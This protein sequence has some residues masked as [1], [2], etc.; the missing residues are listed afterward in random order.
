MPAPKAAPDAPKQTYVK[1]TYIDGSTDEFQVTP[2]N[3][4]QAGVE[5]FASAVTLT[6]GAAWISAGRPD[7]DIEKWLAR[8]AS[9]AEEERQVPLSNGKP[10]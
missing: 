3:V 5:G 7:G 10:R 8:L 6:F 2:L 1:V 9:V 4:Y